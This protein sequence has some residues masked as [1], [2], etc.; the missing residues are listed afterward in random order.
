MKKLILLVALFASA[1]L[2]ADVVTNWVYVVSNIFNNIYSESV[3]T[4]K[5]KSTHYDYY[6]TN[7]VSTV[8]N[9]Y[10][11]TWQTNMS[12]TCDIGQQF[13]LAAS[14]EANRASSFVGAVSNLAD[15]AASSASTAA[16]SASSASASAASAAN[17]RT[18][19]ASECAAALGQINARIN[20]FDQ[21]SGE[22]IT[23]LTSNVIINVNAQ[24][25]S[26]VYTNESGTA[27]SYVT[28]H[29][30]GADGG[31]TVSARSGSAYSTVGIRAWPRPREA[32]KW[33]DFYPAY[34][35]SDEHGL[36]LQYLP[37]ATIP[38][39][40]QGGEGVYP[41]GYIVPEYFYWQSGYI[42]MKVRVWENGSVVA[43]CLTRYQWNDWPNTIGYGGDNG[44]A[45]ALVD[46]QGYGTSAMGTTLAYFYSKT[47][48]DSAGQSINF[49]M[50][51][52]ASH[53]A[54]LEWMRN[55]PIV[56]DLQDRV[57][58]LSNQWATVAGEWANVAGQWSAVSNDWAAF[59]VDVGT[60][61]AGLSNLV[62]NAQNGYPHAYV[63]P[64]GT[65]YS[66]FI[67]YD[68]ATDDGKV[69]IT[70]VGNY[71]PS[72]QYRIVPN[73][74]GSASANYWIFE[75]AYVDTDAN[76]LR[77]HYLPTVAKT[78]TAATYNAGY[79]Y[80]PRDFYWQNGVLY[81]V[82]DSYN[83]TTRSGRIRLK[84]AGTDANAYP[85]GLL[86]SQTGGSITTS[87]YRY[88]SFDSREGTIM[89]TSTSAT[90]AYLKTEYQKVMS[91]YDSVLWFPEKYSTA[92]QPIVEW[93][94]DWQ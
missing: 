18:Q 29:P 83:G 27:F 58:A 49:P 42:Y 36:R 39:K 2:R 54:T 46:R 68:R 81:L 66:N 50:S 84:Y 91:S 76:G 17:S 75:P 8:S 47:R 53:N 10:L 55:G 70:T 12:V 5:I 43:W 74:G 26:Y 89:G 78:I 3:V 6:Y 11:T 63:S 7:H 41:N 94:G 80:V 23:M 25:Y 9:V 77:L 4:Q 33:W 59:R 92:Q 45:M 22:T 82:I 28:V 67:Y 60:S 51:P 93:L 19:A 21:H 48:T 79:L 61:L 40:Y 37:D 38:I 1:A 14:N 31:A 35:D 62:M 15:S 73:Y 86:A 72:L 69:A 90:F 88:M 34:I 30:Y 56:S 20:W 87:Q 44:T 24:D 32:G 64:G 52:S 85:N 65:T 13:L 16:G 71:Y 57:T